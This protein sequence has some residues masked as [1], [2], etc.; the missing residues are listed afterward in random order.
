MRNKRRT[1]KEELTKVSLPLGKIRKLASE[2]SKWVKDNKEESCK[3]NLD[4][5][6]KNIKGTILE[7]NSYIMLSNILEIDDENED[8]GE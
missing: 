1:K 2:F 5:W 8:E 7:Y 4:Y 6:L 3:F